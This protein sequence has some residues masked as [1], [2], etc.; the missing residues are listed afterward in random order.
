MHAFRVCST[1]GGSCFL[2]RLLDASTTTN[3]A[4][5]ETLEIDEHLYR[6]ACM[7]VFCVYECVCV[8][9][10]VCKVVHMFRKTVLCVEFTAHT[11]FCSSCHSRAVLRC[12]HV[13]W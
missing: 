9:T 13:S 3:T 11:M 6:I 1:S 12:V 5:E 8:C 4:G 10:C 2:W 7:S